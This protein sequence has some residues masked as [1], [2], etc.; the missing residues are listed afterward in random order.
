MPEKRITAAAAQVGS[1]LFDTAATLRRVEEYCRK[2]HAAGAALLLF[3][4]ALLGG[5]PKGM[6][7]GVSVGVRSAEGREWF[8]RYAASAIAVPG[9]E[10]QRLQ[11]LAD[12][13]GLTIVMGVVERAGHTLYCSALTVWPGAALRVHRKLMPTAAERYLWGMGDGSTLGVADTPAGRIG[14]AICWENYLPAYRAFLY[15][16]GVELWCAP[17]VDDRPMWQVSMRHIAYEGR[18]FVLSA[19]QY[20][21]RADCPADYQSAWPG[22][23]SDILIRGGS[24]IV[25]PLG[26]VLAG[27]AEGETLLT[28]CLDLDDIP[29]AR[30]DLDAAGH[31]RRPDIF[32]LRV[33]TG[34]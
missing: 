3:P 2:A 29:R 34:Q 32:S 17:T 21:T 1:V 23:G 24:L 30:F 5:Y 31:S 14:A 7:F 27:P 13:L 8:R 16:Q 15:E 28:A 18:C 4:E 6:T 9:P 33:R 26:D 19:C 22:D 10:T 20:F 25:S 11:E 12:E